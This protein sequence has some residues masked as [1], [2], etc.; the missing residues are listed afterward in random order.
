[1]ATLVPNVLGTQLTGARA[2]FQLNG[3]FL[4]WGA[5][6]SYSHQPQ[7]EDYRTLNAYES[8][9]H[10][11]V[12]YTANFSCMQF[13]LIDRNLT[14]FGVQAQMGTDGTQHLLNVI[15]LGELNATVEDALNDKLLLQV[16]GLRF[17]GNSVDVSPNQLSTGNVSFVC[18]RIVEFGN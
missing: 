14:T 9:E 2:V 13:T 6:I 4:A 3:K 7:Y 15:Q 16:F 18:R 11:P 1:M 10:V 17:A 8:V 12:G 5:G